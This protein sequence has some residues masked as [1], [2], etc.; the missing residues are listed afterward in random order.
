M[1]N[2]SLLCEEE[3]NNLIEMVTF[4]KS[5]LVKNRSQMKYYFKRLYVINLMKNRPELSGILDNEF[6][7]PFSLLL[8]STF[9]LF[10]GQCRSSLL[11]LRTALESILH[12]CITK[13]RVWIKTINSEAIFESI[14]Y[15][16]SETKQKLVK[17]IS[18]YVSKDEYSEYF[19]TIERCTFYYKKLSAI[20]HSTNSVSPI[21]TST[22][23]TDLQGDTL[24]NKEGFFKLYKDTLNNIFFLLYFLLRNYL[25]KWDTYDL[26][27]ILKVMFRKE[28]QVNKTIKY[29]KK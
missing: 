19:C 15:R 13:E 26:K 4:D 5:F 18:A 20:V 27:D 16:F 12:F 9:S 23:Y 3:F 6:D 14:D 2:Y 7:K 25:E 17:D 29:I 21:L 22:F 1:V 24:I 8:E 10:S 28:N 11:L